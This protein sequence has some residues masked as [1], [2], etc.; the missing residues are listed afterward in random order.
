MDY[1]KNNGRR[2]PEEEHYK[3]ISISFTPEVHQQLLDYCE[4][5][6]RTCSWVVRKAL[7][8]YFKDHK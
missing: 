2:K 6:E 8:Q 3:K 5:E 4:R 7:E 1:R